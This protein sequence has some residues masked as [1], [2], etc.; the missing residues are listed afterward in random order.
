MHF[1]VLSAVGI[2][3]LCK[4]KKREFVM[5]SLKD[6]ALLAVILA[7]KACVWYFLHSVE[8]T[9]CECT[10]A[11]L[12]RVSRAKQAL[13]IS[14][15]CVALVLAAGIIPVDHP[16]MAYIILALGVLA[17]V[18]IAWQTYSLWTAINA[19]G[20]DCTSGLG[21]VALNAYLVPGVFLSLW[22]AFAIP[23]GI[24]TGVNKYKLLLG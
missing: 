20:C 5:Q 1:S 9:K 23:I 6:S 8:K 4:E 10:D 11:T 3:F 16:Y 7:L 18:S 21:R 19:L 12:A 17:L 24:A 22:L 14:I 13:T 15:C 2:Y